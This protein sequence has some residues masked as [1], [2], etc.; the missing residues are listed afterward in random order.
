MSAID[1][2]IAR[3]GE[4]DKAATKGPWGRNKYGGIGAGEYN[5]MPTVIEPRAFDGSCAFG[6][7]D[8]LTPAQ[9]AANESACIEYRTAA[10][11]L[12]KALSLA[13]AMLRDHAPS[14]H[15][16][17]DRETGRAFHT[18][19]ICYVDWPCDEAETLEKIEALVGEEAEK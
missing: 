13:V 16:H 2:L 10:P 6:L 19:T 17:E 12:A 3:V 15:L 11:L 7:A 1:D 5:L 8:Y 4:L 9:N 14:A 18:C